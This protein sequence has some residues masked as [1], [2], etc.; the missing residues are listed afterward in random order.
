MRDKSC[1]QREIP[2]WDTSQRIIE[3]Q[4]INFPK[5]ITRPAA[6]HTQKKT[7]THQSISRAKSLQI[8]LLP[9]SLSTTR[10]F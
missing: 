9:K 10:K 7:A 3:F 6:T 2:S 1:E 5:V 8:P 4:P